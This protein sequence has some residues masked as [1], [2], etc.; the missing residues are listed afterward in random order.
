MFVAASAVFV[1]C[2][3]LAGAAANPPTL[4]AARLGQGV[5]AGVLAP[6]TSAVIVQLLPDRERGRAFA[7]LGVVT[8]IAMGLSPVVA[9]LIMALADRPDGWRWV[10]CTSAPI[11]AIVLLLALRYLPGGGQRGRQYVD[12]AGA[13][14]LGSTVL[15]VLLP[16][17][18]TCDVAR[19]W[20]LFPIAAAS[21]V[22]FVR[23]ERRIARRQREPLV[24]LG[25]LARTP[26][27][28]VGVAVG[29]AYFSGFSGVWLVFSLY[30]QL[31]L[32]YSPLEAGVAVTP[33]AAG[34]AASAMA[35][36]RLAGRLGST[37]LV[38]GLVLAFAGLVAT[39]VVLRVA[40]PVSAARA[41]AGPLLLAGIGGGCVVPA[42][43]ASALRR[44]APEGA[45]SAGGVLQT[46]QRLGAAIG[47]AAVTGA[48][49]TVLGFADVATAAS[50]GVGVAAVGVGLALVIAALPPRRS[51][52]T[53]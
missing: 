25:L 29:T 2:S 42:N 33:F 18:G 12:V 1:V 15:C 7:A 53:G 47:A 39:A 34:V 45:G 28:L 26:G 23:W 9:G 40:P 36:G 20:W 6:Q 37:L 4:I 14:L 43:T 17:L 21:T 46:G 13:A 19:L 5:A 35:G 30:F 27:Y 50:A 51:P 10:F 48:F 41:V 31:G 16:L 32:G 3:A 38:V 22:C 8:G 44:V 24:D 49:Y 52:A 11:G